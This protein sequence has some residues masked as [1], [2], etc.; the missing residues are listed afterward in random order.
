MTD[1]LVAYVKNSAFDASGDGNELIVFYEKLVQ[2]LN[3]RL[4]PIKY[5]IITILCSRQYESIEDS[6]KF[7]ES[8][9]DRLKSSPDALFLLEISQA[10]KKL[11]LGQHHDCIEHLNSIKERVNSL[12]DVDAKVF[13]GLANVYGLYYKRK[14]DH[15]NYYKACLQYIA[16]TPSSE[17]SDKEK[18]ELSIKMGM[19]ILLGK[20]VYNISELLDKDVINSLMGTYFEWLFHMMKTLGQG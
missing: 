19:S 3:F 16:Y 7:L 12:A 2:K 6:I 17:M 18:K 5:A 9:K 10:D 13:S 15:E 20:N 4:N 11:A 14:D 8:S 1:C